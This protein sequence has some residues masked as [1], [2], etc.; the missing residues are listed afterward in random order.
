MQTLLQAIGDISQSI[1]RRNAANLYN[2]YS[3][4]SV[5]RQ[6]PGWPDLHLA[7]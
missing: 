4:L 5:E 7:A 1:K 6:L 3:L 2:Y